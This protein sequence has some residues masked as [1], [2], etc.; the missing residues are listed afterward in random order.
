MAKRYYDRYRQFKTGSDMKPI[1]GI[2]IP[3]GPQD[4]ETLYKLGNTRLDK[5]SLKY[6]NNPHY[7]W[8]ILSANPSFGGLEWEIPDRTVIRIPFPFEDAIERYQAEVDRHITLY[9]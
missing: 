5:L 2:L 1:P 6:Y 7:G 9:G 3:D 8:L 4:K